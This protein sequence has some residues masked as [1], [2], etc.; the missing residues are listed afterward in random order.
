MTSF[1]RGTSKAEMDRVNKAFQETQKRLGQGSKGGPYKG[2]VQNKP[3]AG[4][5]DRQVNDAQR[6]LDARKNAA[7]QRRN[8]EIART[9]GY[10]GVKPPPQIAAIQERM[11]ADAAKN[12]KQTGPV[13]VAKPVP[14]PKTVSGDAARK[15][16]LGAPTAAPAKPGGLA[17]VK[18]PRAQQQAQFDKNMAQAA[19]LPAAQR[20]QFAQQFQQAAARKDPSTIRPG[21]TMGK[22]GP[23]GS[24]PK[25]APAG[26]MSDAAKTYAAAAKSAMNSTNSGTPKSGTGPK[27]GFGAA[28]KQM[29]LGPRMKSGGSVSSASKRADGIAQRGKTRGKVY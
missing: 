25:S 9:T 10:I 19:A 1:A 2:A 22:P 28:V 23:I 20:A 11:K 4:L 14:L 16:G 7:E 3:V 13:Q 5:R 21:T 24:M 6:E 27:P 8:E 15:L 26:G 17:A 29:G 12:A 18:P